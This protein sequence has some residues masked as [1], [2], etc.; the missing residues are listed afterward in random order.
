MLPVESRAKSPCHTR[1]SSLRSPTVAPESETTRMA[2]P[3][4]LIDSAPTN[5][6]DGPSVAVATAPVVGPGHAVTTLERPISRRVYQELAERCLSRWVSMVGVAPWLDVLSPRRR[7]RA[8]SV[9]AVLRRNWSLMGIAHLR[10]ASPNHP[11]EPYL[12]ECIRTGLIRWQQ[13]LRG[14]GT[15]RARGLQR[16]RWR[17]AVSAPIVRLLSDTTGFQT[18]LLLE[19]LARHVEWLSRARERSAWSEATAIGLIADAAP[20]V[21]NPELLR[22]ARRRLRALLSRQNE[23]GWFP[24][25]RGLDLG[26]H[27]MTLDALA[28]AYHQTR[29][30]ELIEPLRRAVSVL[31]RLADRSGVVAIV[32]GSCDMGFV[33]PYGLE[34]MAAT[35][36]DA[37]RLA[38]AMRHGVARRPFERVEAWS[39]SLCAILGGSMAAC[40]GHPRSEPTRTI[41][42]SPSPPPA[43]PDR[44]LRRAGL[45]VC[46]NERYH[47]VVSTR[48]GGALR[49]V[50]PNGETTLD[51]GLTVVFP[52]RVRTTGRSSATT[53][54]DYAATNVRC[55]GALRRARSAPRRKWG[56]IRRWSR[57]AARWL[58]ELRR[59]RPPRATDDAEMGRPTHAIRD[60]FCREIEFCA[61]M[62]RITD[63]LRCHLP[64]SAILVHAA[65]RAD[66]D[67]LVD[68]APSDGAGRA[69]L[70]FDGGKRITITRAYRDG[71]RIECRSG[72]LVD[73]APV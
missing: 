65:Q 11:D 17:A 64:C 32:P 19:D 1:F 48:H 55:A 10:E 26:C 23:E 67:A 40:A 25:R 9:H 62:V 6:D 35:D 34:L 31:T 28:R 61:D 27:T 42:P 33:S 24:E 58:I 73:G 16:S 3:T 50:W 51:P 4:T 71:K 46:S 15:Y 72:P 52:H 53:E 54:V 20:L 43:Q 14:D 13:S 8:E 29:W 66:R 39:D 12:H 68:G 38:T 49:I 56:R 70:H 22:R 69:P 44:S 45:V 7:G 60:R 59:A 2:S 30:A 18:P 57:R 47:A 5:G 63:H 37:T 21:R 41:P 36:G